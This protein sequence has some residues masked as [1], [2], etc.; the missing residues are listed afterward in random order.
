MDHFHHDIVEYFEQYGPVY[1]FVLPGFKMVFICD[2]K[3]IEHVFRNEDRPPRRGIRS[4]FAQYFAS[5]GM[6]EGITGDDESWYSHRSITAPNMLLPHK[7][8]GYIP[9]KELFDI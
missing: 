6:K 3:D 9:G 2:P 4:S 1:K 5:K 7:S 8:Q